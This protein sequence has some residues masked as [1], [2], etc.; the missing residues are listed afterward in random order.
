MTIHPGSLIQFDGG[1]TY[2]GY[3]TD[4]KRFASLGEPSDD[5]RSFYDIARAAEQASID[6]VKPGRSYGEVYEASQG[7]IRDAGYPQFVQES[8][9]FRWTSIGHNIGLDLHE[10]P[11]IAKGN[12]SGLQVNQ[13]ICI[14]PFFYHDGGFPIWTVSNKY[15]LEDQVLVTNDGHEVLSSDDFISRDIWVA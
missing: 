4:I 3:Y 8:Q 15:G 9:R 12:E 10:M 7:A 14:E 1:C 6:S 2:D 13:V 5:Q 11:G